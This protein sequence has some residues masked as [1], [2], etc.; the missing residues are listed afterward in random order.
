MN[1]L[2][3]SFKVRFQ[4]TV[5]ETGSTS[6]LKM[7]LLIRCFDTAP[8]RSTYRTQELDGD[9]TAVMSQFPGIRTSARLTYDNVAKHAERVGTLGLEGMRRRARQRIFRWKAGPNISPRRTFLF[10]EEMSENLH[11]FGRRRYM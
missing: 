3:A 5:N 9:L 11:S 10:Q 2:S 8:R 7:M 1:V 4:K 6:A